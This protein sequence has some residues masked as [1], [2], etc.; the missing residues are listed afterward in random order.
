MACRVSKPFFALLV[1]KTTDK[2]GKQTR[3]P[4][5]VDSYQPMGAQPGDDE[6]DRE[7]ASGGRV[8]E[9]WEKER[10]L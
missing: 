7:P 9:A 2:G 8:T 3:F 6:T 1:G 5:P 4:R 10:A